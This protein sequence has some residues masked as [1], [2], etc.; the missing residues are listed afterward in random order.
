MC[1]TI[2]FV[3]SSLTAGCRTL[4]RFAYGNLFWDFSYGVEKKR[5]KNDTKNTLVPQL[6]AP[7]H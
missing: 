5:M 1:L 3:P 2:T 6:V 7:D 4:L